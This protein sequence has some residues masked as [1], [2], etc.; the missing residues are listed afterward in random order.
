MK[1]FEAKEMPQGSP[2]WYGLRRGIPTSSEFERIVT[3]AT[4]KFA[5]GAPAYADEL[6][7]AS[8][9]WE[10]QF[11]GSP[12][13]E[14][15]HW[16]EG[17]AR[18]FLAFHHGIASREVGFCLSDCRRYGASTDGLTKAGEPVEIKAPDLHTF[19]KWKR[20]IK[21]T[22]EVPRCHKVQCHGE[23]LVTGSD[24][25]HF[26]A[27]ADHELLENIYL[28]VERSDFTETVGNHV[29]TFCQLLETTRRENLGENYD[30]IFG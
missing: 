23:M 3:P 12:D 21:E 9:G 30:E 19:I 24:V 11:K 6:L 15:G 8:L 22:G 5:A 14:R 28:R 20:E 17:E 10:R 1:I 16:L 2:Q 13:T 29:E 7:A 18:R 27:Y 4:G 26:V 25:C